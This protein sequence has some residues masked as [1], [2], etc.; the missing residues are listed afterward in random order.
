MFQEGDPPKLIPVEDVEKKPI[1][2][3]QSQ[4][5][6]FCGSATFGVGVEDMLDLYNDKRRIT[7]VYWNGHWKC[8][9]NEL[10]LANVDDEHY[11]VKVSIPSDD[12]ILGDLA[13][14]VGEVYADHSL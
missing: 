14:E 9:R 6:S 10:H 3:G 13:V 4:V 11:S 2:H 7:S 12:G 8:V 1:R 5:V